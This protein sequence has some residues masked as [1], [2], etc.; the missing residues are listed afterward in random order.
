MADRTNDLPVV[1]FSSRNLKIVYIK[2]I[3]PHLPPTISRMIQ[4][5]SDL[6]FNNKV[7]HTNIKL[8]DPLESQMFH[9]SQDILSQ[10]TNMPKLQTSNCWDLGGLAN[11]S[12][13]LWCIALLA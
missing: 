7:L 10:T 13:T 9:N 4:A 2:S 11:L 3:T 5:M 12:D 6:K 1:G 8:G